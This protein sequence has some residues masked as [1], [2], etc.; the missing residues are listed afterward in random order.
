MTPWPGNRKIHM[1]RVH[2]LSLRR[3]FSISPAAFLA[4][5]LALLITAAGS[6]SPGQPIDGAKAVQLARDYLS[7]DDDAKRKSLAARLAEYRGDIPSVLKALSARSFEPV[8]AGYHPEEH[9]TVPELLA[10]HPKD[11]L[12]FNVPDSYRPDRPTGLIVFL[13]GG[14]KD[15][16]TAEFLPPRADVFPP[17]NDRQAVQGQGSCSEFFLLRGSAAISRRSAIKSIRLF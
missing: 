2:L 9:F 17:K 16:F 14:G 3:R 13:H 8:K 4:S 1:M 12:F 6:P 11:L 10:K 7:T 15:D 5:A